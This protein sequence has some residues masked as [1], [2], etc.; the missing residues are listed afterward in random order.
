MSSLRIEITGICL[1]LP[2]VW[3]RSRKRVVMKTGTARY[4]KHYEI[5]AFGGSRVRQGY[6]H[7]W[8]NTF[9]LSP[10]TGSCN[11]GKT[12]KAEIVYGWEFTEGVRSDIRYWNIIPQG[13][14]QDKGIETNQNPSLCTHS[15]HTLRHPLPPGHPHQHPSRKACSFLGGWIEQ[16]YQCEASNRA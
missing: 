15:V 4:A 14:S 6:T 3:N 1:T 8:C 11:V 10:P 12:S 9:V 2:S 7:W 13:L 16:H 5:A